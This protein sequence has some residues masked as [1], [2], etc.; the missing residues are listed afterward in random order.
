MPKFW[1]GSVSW[2]GVVREEAGHA[3]PN[4]ARGGTSRGNDRWEERTL[5]EHLLVGARGPSR[6]LHGVLAA[7]ECLRPQRPEEPHPVLLRLDQQRSRAHDRH[8]RMGDGWDPHRS[9]VPP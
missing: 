2:V 3:A 8:R 4:V 9:A 1:G 7:P 5:A 6:L